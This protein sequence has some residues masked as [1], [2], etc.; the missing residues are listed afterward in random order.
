[1]KRS[2]FIVISLLWPVLLVQAAETET[3]SPNGKISVILHCGEGEASCS[4]C[5][6]V[7]YGR[8]NVFEHV[9]LGLQTNRKDLSANLRL[10]S[11][12]EALPHVD[13]YRMIT[14]KR[15][16]C[17]N[18]ANERTFIFANG[19]GD[20][21]T[22]ILRAY[23]DGVAFRYQF[24]AAQSGEAVM[25]ECT[26]F[27][28]PAGK[29]RWLRPRSVDNEGFYP[30]S[31]GGDEAGEWGYPA[32]VEAADGIFALI[33]ESDLQRANCGTFLVNE[34]A[35]RYQVR[36]VEPSLPVSG[37]WTS[38]WHVQMIGPLAT[39]VEST[40]V[41]DVAAPCRLDDTGWIKPGAASWIYWAHNHGSRDCNLLKEY[42][43]L[44]AYMDWGYTLIDAEW[45]RMEGGT[46]RDVLDYAHKKGIRPLLWYN[47]STNWKGEGAF[48]PQYKM[49]EAEVRDKEFAWLQEQGAGG[50]KVDFF[51]TDSLSMMNYY[52]DILED[53]ARH[54][55]LVNFHGGTLPWG[56]QRT[57]PNLITQ[58]A[59]YGA[60]WYNNNERLTTR[61]AC[62]NATLPFTRNVIGSMDYT[63]GT[64]SDSQHPHIT[65]YAHE[66]ALTVLFES[67]MRH[68]PDRP[69]AYKSLPDV[70]KNLLKRLPAAWDDTKLLAG[71]PGESAVV[72]RRKGNDWYIAGVNGK[73][74]PAGLR[75]SLKRLEL[76]SQS[77]AVLIGDGHDDRSFRI[78][79]KYV[80]RADGNI[81]VSCLARGGFVMV[82]QA[83]GR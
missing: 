16:H 78:Q 59:V 68:M 66:L 24:D 54:K 65:S 22:I 17:S 82:V 20:L 30:F 7:K 63:P 81:S 55:L 74:S 40:L 5:L 31:T 51:Y 48:G 1:M 36:M 73:D 53:A 70:V 3:R 33:T 61:A 50:V 34:S 2:F 72:A 32:L 21:L 19:K 67:G 77:T 13:D 10:Q 42:V 75:F 37:R 79:E 12:T 41:T 52:L 8:Q 47:S 4:P 9:S 18:H 60:E 39:V 64:F 35:E 57:Y 49:N 29:P 26:S 23:D 28:V 76:S 27:D 58:E 43:D 45:D 56:W 62:H 71:Y 6:S 15:S 38:A 80:P 11:V 14:G 46:I 25:S 44:A 83:Q 69:E